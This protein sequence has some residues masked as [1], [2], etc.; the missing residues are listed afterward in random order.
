MA[1]FIHA[2]RRVILVFATVIFTLLI[3]L[4]SLSLGHSQREGRNSFLVSDKGPFKQV[5]FRISKFYVPSSPS[6]LLRIANLYPFVMLES[7]GLSKELKALAPHLGLD[8]ML[9]QSC[10]PP[11]PPPPA[12]CDCDCSGGGTS[13]CLE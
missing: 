5:S 3:R 8:L 7:L 11:P 12:D 10:T 13:D 6:Y 9:G 2:Q 1:R 4:V